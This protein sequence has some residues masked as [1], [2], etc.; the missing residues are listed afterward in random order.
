MDLKIP[1]GILRS[2]T[3]GAGAGRW[4]ESQN[5]R[6]RSGRPQK[7]GGYR[8]YLDE[9]II[10]LGRGFVAWT[11]EDGN[12]V[13]NLGTDVKLYAFDD[14]LYDITPLDAEGTLNAPFTT[15]SASAI[16]NVTHVAHGREVGAY[17]IFSG[18]SAVGGIT[19]DGTYTVT[20][21]IDT[22]HYTITHGS[23]AT[24]TAGPGGGA[25]VGYDYE[26]NPGVESSTEGLGWGSG[27]WGEGTWGTPRDTG[28]VINELR[29]WFFAP[30]GVDML[31]QPSGGTIYLWDE[32][33]TNGRA[34]ALANAP[35]SI[36]AMFKTAEGYVTALGVEDPAVGGGGPMTMAWPDRD[37]ITDWLP[38]DE[39]TANVRPVYVGNKLMAGTALE[40]VNL[41]WTDTACY[42]HQY[43]GG[44]FIYDTRLAG[45]NAGLIGGGAYTTA[46]APAAA[47][48]FSRSGFM[49]FDGSV[50]AI[51]RQD[52]DGWRDAVFREIDIRHSHKFWC[53]FFPRFSEVW[54]GYV[55][56]DSPDG[57]PDKY[58][59][60]SI[61]DWSWF[62]G[63]LARTDACVQP[64]TDRSI[65]MVGQDGYIYEHEVGTDA[66][67]EALQAFI[68]SGTMK[69]GD[70]ERDFD[71]RRYIHDVERQT[72]VVTVT[73]RTK[74]RPNSQD[75]LDEYSFS[76]EPD[77]EE[78]DMMLAGRNMDI[79][80]ETNVVGGDIRF[81]V[82]TLIAVPAGER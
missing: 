27:G 37:D 45:E 6:F 62:G 41:I 56:T 25:S 42:L 67:G 13:Q 20:E 51:P 29:R 76:M 52:E 72:G 9:Q 30:Y 55:S 75:Y 44:D 8:K 49:M 54:F 50:H 39:N 36:R 53:Q 43:V 48:W 12:S 35:L 78:E 59:A 81:G 5:F 77:A 57:E 79:E 47:Y 69:M 74:N 70:G 10:G 32:S 40:S 23:A 1:P 58:A 34:E 26:L 71:V 18:A 28:G 38:D 11:T 61:I 21:V 31:C 3:P 64:G 80:I 4:I 19:I 63:P 16:V 33:T 7:I 65:L 17:V 66:D 2:Q 46:G 24:S 82:Q 60:V 14:E 68:R 15:T 73:I 22:D